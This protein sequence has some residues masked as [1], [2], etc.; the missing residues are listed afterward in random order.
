M[1]TKKD[2]VEAYSFSRRRLVTAFLS[3]APGGREVEPTKP[4]RGIVGGVAL[5]VLL[6]AGAAIT[7]FLGGRPNSS[8]LDKGSFVISK[9]TGEQYVVLRGGDDPVIQRVPNFV[10]AQLLLGSA[11]PSVYSVKDK[12]IRDVR[13]GDD[14]GIERAPAGLPATSELIED[15]WTA[16]TED[17]EGIKLNVDEAPQVDPAAG[18][19][20][21]VTTGRGD[22]WL[23][24]ASPEGKAYRFAMPTDPTALSSLL[25][26]LGFGASTQAAVVDDDWLNLF[27]LGPELTLDSFGVTKAGQ[28]V[29]YAELETDLS[30]YR[31]GDLLQNEQGRYYLLA[32]DAPEPLDPFPALVYQAVGAAPQQLPSTMNAFLAAPVTPEQWPSAAPTGVQGGEMCGVL[33]GDDE[34]G[35]SVALGVNPTDDASAAELGAGSHDV[36][37]DP[38]GGAYVLSGGDG[39]ADGGG[40]DGSP[41]VVDAKG[42]KYALIGPQVADYIGYGGYDAPVVPDAWMEFFTPGVDL[43]VNMARR[44]PEDAP[45]AAS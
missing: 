41:Y 10:S 2:L 15:G 36:D 25:D 9:D 42:S 37:V 43:S 16:C 26:S 5:A 28:P 27:P 44:V 4:S 17:G 6:C 32:D 45:D 21:A 34:G 12:Y 22:M 13:L 18:G 40:G 38:S 3:G 23:I 33:V 7:G 35:T 8:W 19:A 14:L 11:E 20:F 29:D 39:E 24:A 1:S 31:I 30:A